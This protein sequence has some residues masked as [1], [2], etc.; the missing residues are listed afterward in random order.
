MAQAENV[1]PISEAQRIAAHGYIERKQLEECAQ[2]L[3]D[4]GCRV[5]NGHWLRWPICNVAGEEQSAQHIDPTGDKKNETGKPTKYGF[6]LIGADYSDLMH[7]PEDQPIVA[8]EGL[9][10]GLVLHQHL[11]L[12]VAIVA[13]S[14]NIPGV[15]VQL[16]NFHNYVIA[17][18]D[19]DK[20]GR[21]AGADS[22]VR[23]TCPK[24]AND[25][26]DL[27]N[28]YGT[29]ALLAEF[30]AG[31]RD[32][33]PEVVEAPEQSS[34]PASE[35]PMG[36][37]ELM[38]AAQAL[39]DDSDNETIDRLIRDS[40]SLS[41]IAKRRV[42]TAIKKKTG[43]P[44]SVME[45][46]ER[47]E[48]GQEDDQPDDLVLA[49]GLAEQI[50]RDDVIA[51]QSF[52]W[53]WQLT[54]VWRVQ[55]DRSVKYWVQSY[56]ADLVP[57]TRTRV[58][59]VADLFKTEVFKADHEFDVGPDECVNCLNGE[60]SLQRDGWMMHPH[61]REHY[62]TSQVP[63][64]YQPKAT[65]GRFSSFL[66]Q[67]FKGDPDCNEKAQALL[68]MVGYSLMAHTRHERFIILVGSG[69]NGKSVFLAVLEALLG[70]HNVAGVQPSQFENK[71]QR[72][73]LL[74]KLAN[75]VTEIKQGEVI[76]DAALKG[77]VSG[78][79]TTVERKF[80]DPF[81]MHPYATC[82][83]G[84]NHMPHTRDFSDALFRRA[85]IVPFNNVFKPELGNCDPNLK[86][87]L[88]AELPGI[89]NMALAAYARALKHGFTMPESCRQAREEWR[90]EA[91]QV[92]QFIES[93]CSRDPASEMRAQELFN[94]Y[95]M[96]AQD[97]NIHRTLT[98]KSF[99]DRL[100]RLG[101]GKRRNE[102]GMLV[103][104]IRRKDAAYRVINGGM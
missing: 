19:N 75:I 14:N 96:W 89:L 90:L 91:D 29:D 20:A 101:F 53:R 67:V 15:V 98:M 12:P 59:S 26:W 44:L 4:A 46:A 42:R 11:D 68:E 35:P 74:N 8:T 31:M 76:D 71:F 34:A 28:E 32:A 62:R 83:F 79:A 17:A 104:G 3:A 30:E 73:H 99:R 55:D 51:A 47:D 87:A 22:G 7:L 85:L 1:T 36:F 16:R 5:I 65:A 48:A 24:S 33:G 94:F 63:V 23:W 81:V 56:L 66:A 77:I 86:S 25:W 58:E 27:L 72:A 6:L 50:G 82:W 54:G 49:C 45:Q 10:D 43:I 78:E 92:Q 69:A 60:L 39:T 70:K 84:T 40:S 38:A 2:V 9:S 103:T 88:V 95:R 37:D 100:D 52:V 64:E 21:K 61:R 13:G 93:E 57:V 102:K 41:A 80:K 18:V 97:N